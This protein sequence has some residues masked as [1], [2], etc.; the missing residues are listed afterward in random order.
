MGYKKTAKSIRV[1]DPKAV[2]LVN[3]KA[4]R[5]NRTAANAAT[6]IILESISHLGQNN[7][8]ESI[9]NGNKCQE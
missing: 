3:Q 9:E 4:V 8:N 6:V 7:T 5:E 1:T 2:E